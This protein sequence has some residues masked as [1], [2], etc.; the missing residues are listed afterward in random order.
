MVQRHAAA[1]PAR[2]S[3]TC[4]RVFAAA[5]RR[6]P[7]QRRGIRPAGRPDARLGDQSPR[8][9]WSAPAA[10][11]G[12]VLPERGYPLT[13]VSSILAR[14]SRPFVLGIIRQE[15]ELRPARASSA[16]ARGMM[17]LL[18]ATAASMA[19][20]TG[21]D[22]SRLHARRPELQHAPRLGLPAATWS[23]SSP[24]PTSWPRPATTPAPAARAQW[25]DFCGDPRGGAHRPARLHRVH[26][27]LRD[28][29]LRDAGDGEHAGLPRPAERRPAPLTLAADLKRGSYPTRRPRPSRPSRPR[30]PTIP[31]PATALSPS[32]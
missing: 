30:R 9:R 26:P 3:A 19:R 28:P 22:Y 25:V 20:K 14:P 2:A 31:A 6:H 8:C 17:Q 23:S 21:V 11:R 10:Q 1:R 18:P 32:N 13:R 24:A 16:D 12:L 29:Q 7:A 15:S 27:V 5:P 4:S